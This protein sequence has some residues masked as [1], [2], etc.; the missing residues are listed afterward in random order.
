M[1]TDPSPLAGRA[2][3]TPVHFRAAQGYALDVEVL[4]AGEIQRRV[5]EVPDRGA[6]RVDLLCLLYVTRG[7]YAHMVDFQTYH[8]STG[9]MLAVQPGQVHRF[10]STRW[11]GWFV[12][13]RSEHTRVPNTSAMAVADPSE[14]ATHM[15]VPAAARAVIEASLAQMAHDANL[16]ASVAVRNALLFHQLRELVVR[17]CLGDPRADATPTVDPVVLQRFHAFRAYVDR[18]HTRWHAV[19]PYARRV[20]CSA[21]SL[22][23]ATEA[24]TGLTAKSFITRR[25]VLEAKR[26]LVHGEASV[27]VI[28]EGLGFDEPTNFVKYFRRETATTPG[29]FRSRWTMLAGEQQ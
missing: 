11:D 6:E 9:S 27:A 16:E 12:V 14:L 7:R 10:G 24:V 28:S 22:T 26:L 3:I 18:E 29:A 2:R 1:L 21:R 8:C 17:V 23:R 5:L 19:D 4:P 25:V 13:V 15:K 20:G